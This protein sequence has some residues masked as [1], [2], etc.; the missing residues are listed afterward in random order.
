MFPPAPARRWRQDSFR[1]FRSGRPQAVVG[2]ELEDAD[3]G[4]AG[5]HA[6]KSPQTTGSHL[7]TH[8]SIHNFPAVTAGVQA[9]LQLGWKAFGRRWRDRKAVAEHNCMVDWSGLFLWRARR[10]EHSIFGAARC[11]DRGQDEDA[12]AR[13]TAAVRW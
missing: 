12:D 7:A 11:R 10:A 9:P 13:R 1:S 6:F 4:L 8:A 3:A 2:A 5:E